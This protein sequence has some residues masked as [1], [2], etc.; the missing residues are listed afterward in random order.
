M[1]SYDKICVFV[2][3]MLL[4]IF[5]AANML[6]LSAAGN[7]SGRPY[8]VEISRIAEEIRNHGFSQIELSEYEYV[9]NVELYRGDMEAYF[10]ETD[11]DYLVREIDGNLYRFDYIALSGAGH[12]DI[13]LIF[14]ILLGTVSLGVLGVLLFVRQNILKPF[15]ALR[16]VPYELSRGNLTVPM[17]ENKSRF[18]GKFVWGMDMLRENIE[19]QKERELE[20]QKEKKTLV[21]S[22]SHDIK[23]PLSAIK[24][25][26]KALSKG[27]YSEEE[28]QR[29]IAECINVKADEIEGFVSQIIK[30]SSEDFLNLE[31]EQ[32]E[33]YLSQLVDPVVMYYKEKLKLIK[34]GFSVG[35]YS[36]CLLKGDINR[37]IEVIQNIME[38]AIKY[39]DGGSIQVAFSEE[40]DCQLVTVKNSGCTLQEAEL[41]HVFESF[42][43]GSNTGSN[44]GSGLGL[45]ICRQLMHK[46]DG[47]VFAQIRGDEMCVT[48]VYR[49]AV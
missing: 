42:W 17:K 48:A 24:L 47:D 14:N 28:K 40:E 13:L 10:E 33:F 39:G 25:Y 37:S 23:T 44:K 12:S 34:V 20:L 41:P 19:Q 2:T 18:F 36:D 22:V 31:A 38:N 32:G 35:A 9:T 46:M 21:L 16:D 1:K 43:R 30:A 11:S 5:A 27:L 8:R 3:A 26:A 15:E 49:K 6:L 29:E 4:I 7:E 45:Y